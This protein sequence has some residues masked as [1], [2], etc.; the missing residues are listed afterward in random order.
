MHSEAQILWDIY[1]TFVSK[2]FQALIRNNQKNWRSDKTFTFISKSILTFNLAKYWYLGKPVNPQSTSDSFKWKLQKLS[3]SQKFTQ[4]LNNV[5]STVLKVCWVNTPL[6]PSRF[7]L[8]GC[9]HPLPPPAG[10]Q[11]MAKAGGTSILVPFNPLAL[12][13]YPAV[14]HP[15]SSSI[16][17]LIFPLSVTCLS[18]QLV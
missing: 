18:R 7:L 3:Y 6:T 11:R 9:L 13:T 14:L 10:L 5:G 1:C 15:F 4:S 16:S 8:P 12:P 2:P 17:F